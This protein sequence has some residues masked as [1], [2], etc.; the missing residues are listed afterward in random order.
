MDSF[1]LQFSLKQMFLFFIIT[2]SVDPIRTFCINHSQ[3]SMIIPFSPLMINSFLP[4]QF[5][6]FGMLIPSPSR[7]FPFLLSLASPW[8]PPLLPDIPHFSPI[9][10]TLLWSLPISPLIIPLLSDPSKC[11]SFVSPF[12]FPFCWFCSFLSNQ[13]FVFLQVISGGIYYSNL[14][15][16]TIIVFNIF[17]S[18]W[19]RR[20]H[21]PSEPGPTP[22]PGEAGQTGECIV[23]YAHGLRA[24]VGV[25]DERTAICWTVRAEEVQIDKQLTDRQKGSVTDNRQNLITFI[26][27][28]PS[29]IMYLRI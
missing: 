24:R 3:I 14:L 26:H 11:H 10:P 1:Q 4:N 17:R 23:R 27:F 7:H 8:Y 22:G 25:Q 20:R 21:G 18:L 15:I 2:L 16:S 19:H 9:S 12:C 5:D 13:I 28:F 29:I 6:L